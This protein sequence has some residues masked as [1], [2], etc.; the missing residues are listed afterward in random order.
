MTLHITALYT[1]PIK[2][3]ARLE[4]DHIALSARGLQDD[5]RWMIVSDQPDEQGKFLTQREL[6]RL[7]VIQPSLDAEAL[8]IAAPEQGAITIPLA[9]SPD[10][11]TRSVVVW[12][13]TVAANDEGDAA[14]AWLS[15]FLA[16]RVRLV[17]MADAHYRRVDEKYVPE[18]AQTSF[19]DGYP[20]MLTNE[21]SLDDLNVRIQMRG[22]TPIPMNRFRPNIVIQGAPPFAEDRWAAFS[23][24]GIT[25]EGVKLCVRCAVL[26]VDQVAGVV[27]DVQ[28]PSATLATFR[29]RER[30]VV[31]GQNVVHRA[32]GALSV[33][34]A[35]DVVEQY[36]HTA[37]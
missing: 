37:P 20:I 31:F 35:L 6:P 25:F 34:D 7:A 12:R 8:H 10:A 9:L 36:E 23:I 16:Y 11:P 33:G 32:L 26:T 28:E 30:G 15:D 5:R 24:N 27:P 18:T 2:A 14:A 19:T 17:R 13:D 29:K 4:H 3:C 22:K 1:Y 21:A